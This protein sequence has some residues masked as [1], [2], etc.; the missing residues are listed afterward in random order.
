MP[1]KCPTVCRQE[2]RT[3]VFFLNDTATT[4]IYTLSLHDALPIS[5][6]RRTGDD[7]AARSDY[8]RPAHASGAQDRKSKR[9]NSSHLAISYAVFCLK[10]N[11]PTATRAE[12]AIPAR[13]RCRA[14][15]MGADGCRD[16]V[17]NQSTQ[18]KACRLESSL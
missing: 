15:P 16:V 18:L 14:G 5:P 13:P 3:S 1:R 9:L 6:P 10:K 7:P 17:A 12:C 11:R 4:E 8:Q 2:K